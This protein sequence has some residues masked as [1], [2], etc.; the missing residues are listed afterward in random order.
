MGYWLVA[1]IKLTYY[2]RMN[3]DLFADL[4]NT[5]DH[6]TAP[7]TL[8]PMALGRQAFL[9]RQ[10]GDL[11]QPDFLQALLQDIEAVVAAAPFRHMQTTRGHSLSA[12]MSNCGQRGW[13]S[14]RCGYRYSTHDPLTGL[15]WPSMPIV[16]RNLAQQAARQ[17]GFDDFQP[18]ACLINQYVAGSR[19]GLH[20]D[21]DERDLTQPIVSVSL[22]IPAMFLWGGSQRQ[23]STQKILLQHGDVLVWGGEDRLRYHGIA[24]LKPACHPLLGQRRLNLTFRCAG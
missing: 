4:Y 6:S 2:K 1:D 23:G 21:K 11:N 9:F 19:M 12:A 24:A 17:A 20:Q 3:L 10:F 8:T 14:D 18:D 16:L 5:P 15:L 7:A 13:V 22:G